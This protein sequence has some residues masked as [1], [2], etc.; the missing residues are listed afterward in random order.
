MWLTV[1][2]R[3]EN[4]HLHPHYHGYVNDIQVIYQYLNCFI[5][6]LPNFD[7]RGPFCFDCEHQGE[8]GCQT[9]QMCRSDEVILNVFV[10]PLLRVMS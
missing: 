6:G 4:Y 1:V 5:S 3:S 9:V 10:R 8:D 2:I 7:A